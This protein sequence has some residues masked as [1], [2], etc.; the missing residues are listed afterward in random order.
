MIYLLQ[1]GTGW[2]FKKRPGIESFLKAIGPPLFEVVIF[3]QDNGFVS[4]FATSLASYHSRS[5]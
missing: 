3:T 4:S 2:R 1:Y 5:R